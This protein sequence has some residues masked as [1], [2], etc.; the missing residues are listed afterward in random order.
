M[1]DL[2]FFSLVSEFSETRSDSVFAESFAFE[3]VA[4][5]VETLTGA[6]EERTDDFLAEA[7]EEFVKDHSHPTIY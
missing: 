3:S 4:D 6:S 2:R 5:R 1:F 7:V